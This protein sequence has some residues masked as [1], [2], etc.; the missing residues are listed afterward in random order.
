MF[1][2]LHPFSGAERLKNSICRW[3]IEGTLSAGVVE[4]LGVVWPLRTLTNC[5][6]SDVGCRIVGKFALESEVVAVADD[7]LCAQLL[8]TFLNILQQVVDTG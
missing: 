8:Y 3:D 7:H 2:F 6:S 5:R 4:R 1:S